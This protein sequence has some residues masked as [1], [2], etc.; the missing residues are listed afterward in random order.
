MIVEMVI[1]PMVPFM[2]MLGVHT[3]L[4]GMIGGEMKI[5]NLL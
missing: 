3:I 1:F 2:P 5:L 4:H